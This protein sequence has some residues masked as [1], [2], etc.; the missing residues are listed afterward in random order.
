MLR[1]C[2]GEEFVGGESFATDASV[3]KADARRQRAVH[4]TQASCAQCTGRER[5]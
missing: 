4:G 1:R 3:I 2:I 5:N